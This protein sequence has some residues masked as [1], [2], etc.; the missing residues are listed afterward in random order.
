[1]RYFQVSEEDIES[2]DDYQLTKL[3][4]I[5]LYSEANKFGLVKNSVSVALNITV[6]DGG[7]DGHISW[8]EGVPST[9]WLPKRYSL[10][11]VKATDMRPA[12]CKDEVLRED[13]LKLKP[14]VEDVIQKEG[15]YILFHNRRL[16][17]E[18]ILRRIKAFKEAINS[19]LPDLNPHIEIYNAEKIAAWTNQYVSAI[20]AV[21][22]WC[23][24]PHLLGASTWENWHKHLE[25]QNEFVS[26]YELDQIIT[27]L[28]S[29]LSEEK[30][31]ARIIGLPG[32]GKTRLALEI[33]RA[34]NT[35]NT[36]LSLLNQS[37]I[38]VDA[39]NSRSE[40]I[41]TIIALRDLKISGVIV[42]DNCD[43]ELHKALKSAV[44]HLDSKISILTIDYN[45]HQTSSLDPLIV[46]EEISN[47]VIEG[48]LRKSYPQMAEDDLERIA[49]FAEGFPSIATLLAEARINDFDNIGSIQDESL[50]N[51]LL[52]G[53]DSEDSTALKVI[54]ACAIFESIGF[55]EE[56]EYEMKY[57]AEAICGI[58]EDE[59][60]E[61]CSYFI[62]KKIMV[63]YGRYIK[64]VPKTLAITLAAQWWQKCRPKK[65]QNILVDGNLPA[66]MVS[67]LCNQISKLHFLEHAKEL[68]A[69]LCGVQ[70]PF[71]QAEILSSE[72]GSSIFCSFVEIDPISTVQALDREFSQKSI[73]ELKE[74]KSGRRNLVRA[75]EKL[76][77]WEET[78][79]LAAKI[80][81]RF[82]AA[83]NESWSNNATGQF[84]QLFHY[85]LSGTQ[86]DFSKRLLII[87]WALNSNEED[88]RRIGIQ[89][90]SH[91]L[92][93]SGFSRSVGVELQGS[94]PVMEEW[95]PETWGDVFDYWDE[96]IDLLAQCLVKEENLLDLIFEAITNNLRGL[97]KR[98]YIQN[99]DK[100]LNVFFEKR[101]YYWPEF[102][103]NLS[104]V[105]KYEG[106]KLPKW[107]LEKFEEWEEALKPHD[108]KTELLLWVTSANDE[109]IEKAQR[110]DGESKYENTTHIRI[111]ELI[112]RIYK[113][114][115][116]EIL[117]NLD[118]LLLG[119]QKQTFYF[120]KELAEKILHEDPTSDFLERIFEKVKSL[121]STGAEVKV[122]LIGGILSSLQK[123]EPS[124]FKG[125]LS[126]FNNE[127]Y[128]SQFIKIIRFIEIDEHILK[129]LL[130][131]VL[132][133]YI[134]VESLFALAYGP[135]L[136]SIK[137]EDLLN[138]VETIFKRDAENSHLIAWKI[139][140]RYYINKRNLSRDSANL[141]AYFLENSPEIIINHNIS[142]E[143]NEILQQL[144]E[145]SFIEK[146]SLSRN[147]LELCLSIL[148]TDKDYRKENVIA[149]H[150]SI[151]MKNT[152]AASWEVISSHLLRADSLYSYKLTTVLGNGFFKEDSAAIQNIPLDILKG[153]MKT[154]EKAPSIL[155]NLYP[156]YVD[157]QNELI[158]YL[159]DNYCD[160][161][162]VLK[163]IDRQLR[164]FSWS[165]SLVTYY[166]KLESFYKR[167]VDYKTPIGT[168][169]LKNIHYIQQDIKDERRREEEEKL[170]F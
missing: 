39:N 18:Q 64:L 28:R 98:G 124:L 155:S 50:V 95:K 78:F 91:A 111:Q 9:D 130:N 158:D 94:R 12:K 22:E 24:K 163:N 146:E 74:V 17:E 21:W 164:T 45:L 145:S 71:G 53:R 109:Y 128:A 131:F 70:A 27:Q 120:G 86:A 55:S 114:H 63:Q 81:A 41:P 84:N 96:I 77:F 142:Y 169:A 36:E 144:Y 14:R 113:N 68:T 119:E 52:W 168:W 65:A 93:S 153:W 116:E 170:R 151:I 160:D 87:E 49:I 2:L 25:Y 135:A 7:E 129:S 56:K 121:L 29:Y 32:K 85:T 136:N 20:Y 54:E 115:K 101:K 38:Y 108:I 37:V 34:D 154:D 159:L 82:A 92:R 156:I 102:L 40:L 69:N 44:E 15:C 133:G 125:F 83:E 127:K 47:D 79:I 19:V 137:E 147:L 59:F 4:S 112:D 16:V 126:Q 76:C 141:V 73:S 6:G 105:V 167:Y 10:F 104:K 11:Q 88:V 43:Y 139:Y 99:L 57:V 123:I 23:R 161:E 165:G 66:S 107:V 3:L 106:S 31:V 162:R 97:I 138:F 148:E 117:S 90:A 152:P 30:K 157:E 134:E 58:D 61:K 103:E 110:T 100:S 42:V 5:L 143:V 13:K 118:V 140:Y 48:I 75:L 122:E 72:V 67:Q 8:E 46:L 166:K 89:A 80:L 26:S 60:Y 132:E 35:D 149:E 150:M 51:K 1:M 62:K 33:F